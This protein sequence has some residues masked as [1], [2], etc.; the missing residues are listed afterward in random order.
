[1]Q[2]RYTTINGAGYSYI[3][4]PPARYCNFLSTKAW[5]LKNM[6][7][8]MTRPWHSGVLSW[9]LIHGKRNV[10]NHG[11]W[12]HQNIVGATPSRAAPWVKYRSWHLQAP[13]LMGHFLQGLLHE[14][15]THGTYRHHILWGYSCKGY[16]MNGTNK[17]HSW[18]LQAPKILGLLL[19]GLLHEWTNNINTRTHTHVIIF[20]SP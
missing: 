2:Y 7:I 8:W 15:H 13:Y 17:S 5:K 6:H 20:L 12:R 1:M 14:R 11:A 9:G 16:S 18:H 19:Q 4:S 10:H 3:S